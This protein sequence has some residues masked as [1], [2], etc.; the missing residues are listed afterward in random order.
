VS[1]NAK[2]VRR[3]NAVRIALNSRVDATTRALAQGWGR[4][5]EEISDE[6]SAAIDE[7]LRIGDGEWPSRAQIARAGRASR[8]MRATIARLEALSQ[9][10]GVTVSGELADLVR[11]ADDWEK[12][13]VGSQLPSVI[14]WARVDPAA[15]DAIIKRTTGRVES[16][17]RPL[18]AEQAAVMKQTLIR[19][20]LVGDNPK[21]AASE[22]LKRLG[23]NFDGG[24]RRAEVITRTEMISAH[25]EAA[26]ASRGANADVLKGW[27]WTATKSDR[28][29]PACLAMD[30]REFA[31]DASGP[32]GH[33]CCRCTA[34][35]IT[36]SYRDLGLDVD[37]PPSEYQSGRDWFAEQPRSTQIR[38]MGAERLR[39]L[40]VGDLGWDDLPIRLENPDWRPSYV[41]RPLAA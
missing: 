4:A 17:L 21:A 8:A 32:D 9:A 2:T 16:R 25:R 41:V 28:T 11:M 19:G 24:R 23:G 38:I 12:A 10:A 5:F 13:L 40:D 30:G 31:V 20:V 6:W 39:R 35:P 1:V 33:P 26:L 3:L 36:K 27:M 14:D 7:L 37:E 29:C 18:P 22:M 15:V 34:V